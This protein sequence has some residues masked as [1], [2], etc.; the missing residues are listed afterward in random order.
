M[1]D[2]LHADGFLGTNAN[3]AADVTLILSII[4]ALVFTYGAYL[5]KKAQALEARY[6]KTDPEF[7]GARAR[8]GNLFNT[9]RW[10]QTTGAVINI[11]LV[12]WLMLLPYRDF[13]LSDLTPP[14]PRADIFYWVTTVHAVIGFFAFT[15]GN[16]VVLRG[17]NLMI[18]AL[19]FN[20]YKPYMR[21][22]YGLYMITTLLGI[23]V[24][25]T[26]FV[27]IANPPVFK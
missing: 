4:V 17:N 19:K 1:V 12:F 2:I 27:T 26:W 9:H 21:T 3:L 13:V 7:E 15:F 5:A 24:Y 16:F 22:A 10:V 14:R 11:V 25:V 6:E 23:W 20:N 8:A 18:D